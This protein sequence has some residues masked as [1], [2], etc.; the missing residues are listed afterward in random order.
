MNTVIAARRLPFNLLMYDLVAAYQQLAG[1]ARLE[2]VAPGNGG[3]SSE[4]PG[5]PQPGQPADFS[6]HQ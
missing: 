5:V 1:P 4:L 3:A 6:A 2:L